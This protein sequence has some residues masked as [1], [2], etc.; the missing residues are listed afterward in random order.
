MGF[1]A[2]I[3]LPLLKQN[4]SWLEQSVRSALD[5]SVESE[6]LVV[7]DAA[8]PNSNLDCLR[9]LGRS[10][11]HLRVVECPPPRR[12]AGALNLGIQVASADRI[13]LLLSDDWLAPR[14]VELCL[15]H[16]ADIVSTSSTFY[17]AD[18]IT[19]L[20]ELGHLRKMSTYAKLR[21][22]C[23]RA[24]FLSHFFLFRRD[25]LE[26][27]GGADESLGDSPG[28]DDFDMI[29]T[30]LEQG[31]SVAIVEERLY[32]M[33]DHDGERLTTR[34]VEEM[35]ATLNRILNKHQV[36]AAERTAILERHLPWLGK[37]LSVT[38]REIGGRRLPA[39]LRPFQTFYRGA[40]PLETRVK[41]YRR[42]IAPFFGKSNP[43]R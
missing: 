30:L 27:A 11:S 21:G 8:T 41:I 40:I 33:R 31:A 36:S 20:P 1:R 38:H 39:L 18:G 26:R 14:A 34:N 15:A 10:S 35:A 37:P 23:A 43:I 22:H 13:G 29:W 4:D 25:A 19:P 5:Q 9:Q 6:V 24:E 28:I 2:S 42:W 3:I 7:T 17:D 16:S 12:F 32:N